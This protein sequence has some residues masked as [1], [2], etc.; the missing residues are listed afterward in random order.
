MQALVEPFQQHAMDL[1]ILIP[2][3]QEV[4]YP[5]AMIEYIFEMYL[6]ELK[7]L[8][9]CQVKQHLNKPLFLQQ[10]D[11]HLTLLLF[12]I[13]NVTRKVLQGLF[14]YPT[15]FLPAVRD[16]SAGEQHGQ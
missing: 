11:N 14:S 15:F 9:R 12:T 2:L 1:Q 3:K 13:L 8:L 16:I 7:L 4:E 10:L 6:T 5:Q